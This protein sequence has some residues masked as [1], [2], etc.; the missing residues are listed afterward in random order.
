MC[1]SY[2]DDIISARS[3]ASNVT[4]ASL[5]SLHCIL[6]LTE[7]LAVATADHTSD[8]VDNYASGM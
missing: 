4:L 5:G 7:G 2:F 3:D 6:V 8:K 1:S